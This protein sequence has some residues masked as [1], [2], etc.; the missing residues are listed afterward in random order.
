MIFCCGLFDGVDGAIARILNKDSSKGAFIDS[1]MDR[2]SEFVIFLGILIYCWNETLW[3]FLDMKLII[4]IAFTSTIMIS[5]SRARGETIYKG[6][7]DVGL[8]ARSERLFYLFIISIIVYFYSELFNIFLFI[9]MLLVIATF[10]FRG[11]KINKQIKE[12]LSF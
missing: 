12:N 9:Y 1:T 7:Y 4:F 11:L 8:M 5:Y 3:T 2:F 6:D 10:I